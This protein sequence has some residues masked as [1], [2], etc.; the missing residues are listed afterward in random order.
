[1]PVRRTSNI[2]LAPGFHDG[3]LSGLRLHLEW[4]QSIW[5]ALHTS[6]LEDTS[7]SQASDSFQVFD[8]RLDRCLG[9]NHRPRLST[10]KVLS[11]TLCSCQLQHPA[12]VFHA[13]HRLVQ[14][15]LGATHRS[16]FGALTLE[17]KSNYGVAAQ[18]PYFALFM[19]LVTPLPSWRS[20]RAHQIA[21]PSHPCRLGRNCQ[22][23]EH[24][25]QSH[26]SVQRGENCP[27]GQNLAWG[28]EA[29]FRS[30]RFGPSHWV[31]QAGWWLERIRKSEA[32]AR[33]I[34]SWPL[35]LLLED[36][37]SMSSSPCMQQQLT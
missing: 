22:S 19:S 17:P 13:A 6:T 37:S 31:V 7:N 10:E 14:K 25:P 2:C 20:S 18:C 34:N 35:G 23:A 28:P 12:E 33:E 15:T 9:S 24:R 26:V 36:F 11:A 8:G 16:L 27:L 3:W 1:M 29:Q 30:L 32:G 5:I 4:L 21:L